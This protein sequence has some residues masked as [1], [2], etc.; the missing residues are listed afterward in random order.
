MFDIVR[1][2]P[3]RKSEWNTFVRSSKNGTFLIERE[4][5][6]YHSDRFTDFSL[7]FYRGGQ[8][9]ALLPADVSCG[10]LRSHGGL[11]YG[12]L[13]TGTGATAA[14]VVA[15]FGELNA[16]MRECGISRIV[17]KAIP[18]IYHRVPSE[19]D[20]YAIFRVCNARIAARD[21]SST[22]AGQARIKWSRDRRYGINRV[23]NN[24][25]TVRQSDDYR[26][27]WQVLDGNLGA[28][29]GV[30]P[31]HTVDEMLLLKSRFPR[32]ICLYTAVRDG[33]TLGG[34]VLYLTPQTVHAQYISASAEGKHLRVIDGIYDQ[35][36]NRDFADCAFFDFG[37]ST[38]DG[39]II[40]NESL[41]YQKEGFGGRA[42]CYD[43]YEWQP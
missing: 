26:A 12:G 42:V 1:Y 25:I 36:L 33:V 20:L 40:L 16:Y 6:D 35:I 4:Y 37:K 18:W 39:G 9:F 7:M 34:T 38:E 21:I 5:M 29:Y 19:E 14:A 15:L 24:G 28:K 22:I 27:F 23:K 17:Y 30:R 31:V 8:L 11:T 13:I 10:V 3:E 43:T 2:S 32:N 41:I